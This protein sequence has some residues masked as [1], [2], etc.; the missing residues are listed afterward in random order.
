MVLTVIAFA[1]ILAGCG[2]RAQD[3]GPR[4]AGQTVTRDTPPWKAG[5]TPFTAAGN[6]QPADKAAWDDGMKQRTQ[7]QNEYVR[8]G[9]N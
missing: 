2:E 5:A 4:A 3:Q 7:F 8:I 9:S 1:L 6:T